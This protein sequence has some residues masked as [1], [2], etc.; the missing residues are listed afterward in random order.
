MMEKAEVREASSELVQAANLPR[1]LG[2][3]QL[4]WPGVDGELAAAAFVGV[5]RALLAGIW[6]LRKSSSADI[7]VDVAAAESP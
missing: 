6:P 1:H 5:W 3:A 4:Q 2:H 7:I